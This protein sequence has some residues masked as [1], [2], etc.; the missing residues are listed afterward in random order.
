MCCLERGLGQIH[1]QSP[2]QI[3]VIELDLRRIVPV[4]SLT[5]STLGLA[6]DARSCS[7]PG[8]HSKWELRP[9]RRGRF[10]FFPA[11]VVSSSAEAALGSDLIEREIRWAP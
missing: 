7:W 11:L 10:R 1:R 5:I 4:R 8:H 9:P 3:N 6:E 2:A